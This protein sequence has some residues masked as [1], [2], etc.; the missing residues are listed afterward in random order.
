MEEKR[1]GRVS[2]PTTAQ[3]WGGS[4]GVRIP[5]QVARKYGIVNGSQLNIS[6]DGKNIILT[7]VDASYTLD[8]LLSQ[9]IGENPHPEY[10]SEPA[11]KEEL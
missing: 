7:P 8:E 5:Q 9:C 6:E 1:R 2:M 11:G 3:K 10:F 4:I